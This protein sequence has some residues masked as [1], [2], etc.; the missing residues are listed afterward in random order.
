[1][2]SKS[3]PAI[4]SNHAFAVCN[5]NNKQDLQL[6]NRLSDYDKEMSKKLRDILSDQKSLIAQL[7]R[8]N[9][10]NNDEDT[11][12][13]RQSTDNDGKSLLS[14]PSTAPT[15]DNKVQQQQQKQQQRLQTMKSSPVQQRRKKGF[16]IKQDSE[17]SIL[18][19]HRFSTDEESPTMIRQT[20]I[21]SHRHPKLKADEQLRN[22]SSSFDTFR[23]YDKTSRLP[24][25]ARITSSLHHQSSLRSSSST[26]S[27]TSSL[28]SIHEHR[29]RS[30]SD[31]NSPLENLNNKTISLSSPSSS[32]S[33]AHLTN[34][35][36]A[37]SLNEQHASAEMENKLQDKSKDDIEINYKDQDNGL[38]HR[39]TISAIVDQ[40]FNNINTPAKNSPL[41]NRRNE[42]LLKAAHHWRLRS[43]QQRNK[44]VS[45][46]GSNGNDPKTNLVSSSNGIKGVM[47]QPP[48]YLRCN[49]EIEEVD[50]FDDI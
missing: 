9:A 32:T 39:R 8:I 29:P 46:K 34:E 4:D 43:L 14:S 6:R 28:H 35:R 37:Y 3:I 1:M 16:L 25:L 7:N 10:K 17:S 47:E 19:K 44:A 13:Q 21:I 42:N 50:V 31:Q 38:S 18:V 49:L 26:S 15:L 2:N 5:K 23:E 30:L 40:T 20:T 11:E 33:S 48:R 45:F 12:K 22:R 41:L 36:R 24:H 27:S